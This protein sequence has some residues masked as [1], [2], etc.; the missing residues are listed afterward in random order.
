VREDYF[1]RVESIIENFERIQAAMEVAFDPSLYIGSIQNLNFEHKKF[2]ETYRNRKERKYLSYIL[3]SSIVQTYMDLVDSIKTN[4]E[5]VTQDVVNRVI[6]TNQSKI[7]LMKDAADLERDKGAKAAWVNIIREFMDLGDHAGAREYTELARQTYGIEREFLEL[8][9][10]ID[11]VLSKFK[12]DKEKATELMTEKRY[13]DALVILTRLNASKPDDNEVAKMYETTSSYV[14]RMDRLIADARGYEDEGKLKEAYRT[15]ESL[16]DYDPENEEARAKIERYSQ[17]LQFGTTE[18]VM[19]CVNCSGYGFCNVCKGSGLCHVCNGYRKCIQCRGAGFFARRCPYCVCKD[20]RGTGRCTTCEGRATVTC[21]SCGG[22]GSMTSNKTV[23]CSVCG[24]SGKSRF[25]DSSCPACGGSGKVAIRVSNLCSVCRGAKVIPCPTCGGS[26]DC[27]TCMG[28]GH[29]S[30]C[31][32]CGGSGVLTAP[33][34][35]CNRTGRCPECGGTGVCKYCK[36]SGKCAECNGAGVIVKKVDEE[37]YLSEKNRF[38][39]VAT[40]PPGASVYLDGELQGGSPLAIENV[41]PGRHVIRFSRVGYED[42]T[43]ETVFTKNYAAK[44]DI[45]LLNK[46]S[47]IYRVVSISKENHALVFRHYQEQE[48]GSFLIALYVDGRN[49]WKALGETVL[50]HEI[51]ELKREFKSSYNPRLKERQVVDLSSLIL[52]KPDGTEVKLLKNNPMQ[53]VVYRVKLYDSHGKRFLY[54][55]EGSRLGELTVYNITDTEVIF[56]DDN[57]NLFTVSKE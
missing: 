30:K 41:K 37:K 25:R 21:P 15:W 31:S 12:E 27:R 43:Y 56:K 44:F 14:E 49:D 11:E 4:S 39:S 5:K 23:S 16:L 29:T 6:D 47:G 18:I 20:C 57:D 17:Q 46:K 7:A 22:A 48:D 10:K 45:K 34:T 9:I 52:K 19:T 53:I 33:C 54:A 24:G 3:E 50:G 1:D 35:F 55:V 51:A 32:Y 38:I 42:F 13:R 26:G 40:D 8:Q 2:N 28:R 36:G